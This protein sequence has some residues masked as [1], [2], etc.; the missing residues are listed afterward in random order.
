MGMTIVTLLFLFAALEFG[1]VSLYTIMTELMSSA[2]G[3]LLSIAGTMN[4]LGVG[5]A[6]VI[7]KPVWEHHGY[8]VVTLILGLICALNVC[9]IWLCINEGSPDRRHTNSM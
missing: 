9:I 5:T 4:S 8:P 3:T 6:P 7:F 1:F 2:R